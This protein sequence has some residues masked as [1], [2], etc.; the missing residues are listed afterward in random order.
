MRR[1]IVSPSR[2]VTSQFITNRLVNSVFFFEKK[3]NFFL[4]VEYFFFGAA[5]S[6]SKK[7]IYR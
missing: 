2:H 1:P 6:G 7:P 4:Y 5:C 3:I